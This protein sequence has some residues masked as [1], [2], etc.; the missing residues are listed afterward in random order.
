MEREIRELE[1]EEVRR[2]NAYTGAFNSIG[3]V[4]QRKWF[5]S[6]DRQACGFVERRHRGRVVWEAMNADTNHEELLTQ[7]SKAG[8]PGPGNGRLAYP[9]Y[10]HGV[11]HERSVVTSRQGKDILHD[12]KVTGFIPR[13]GWMPVLK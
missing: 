13:K 1:D 2:T 8:P 3:S 11:D 6:M 10:I 12:E 5:L 7:V 9:F 4:H